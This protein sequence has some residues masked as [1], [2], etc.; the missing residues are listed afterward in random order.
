[1]P[2]TQLVGVAITVADL[3][4]AAAFWR[5]GLGLASGPEHPL[6]DAAWY[7]VL[8]LAP[9]TTSRAV[10]VAVGRQM[11]ELIAF[12]PPGRAYPAERSSNDPWFEHVALVCGDIN[13]VWKRLESASPGVVTRGEPV[14]LPPNTGSVTAFKFRDPDGHPLEL[15]AFPAGAGDPVW[16]TLPGA[17]IGGFD[18]TAIAVTDLDR[19]IAFYTGLLGLRI[20]GRSLNEGAGQ[21]RLDGLAGCEVDV[22]ALAPAVATPHLELLHYRTPAGRTLTTDFAVNDLAAVRQ[23][24]KVGEID[25]LVRRLEAAGAAFVSPGVVPLQSGSKAAAVRDPDGHILVLMDS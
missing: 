10:E 22:V 8:G 21:D 16:Q 9:G 14:R 6:G 17:G 20:V 23:L 13:A 1:M 12:D 7:A 19:S 4:G 15:I 18:H 25:A 5:N 11:V 24:Y 2:V 3:A